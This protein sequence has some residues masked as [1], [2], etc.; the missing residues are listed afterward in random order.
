MERVM[1]ELAK[2][3]NFSIPDEG[4][5]QSPPLGGV[6]KR[7]FDI[8][9]A[10]CAIVVLS[11]LLVL[12]ALLVKL[13]DG[14]PIFYGHPRVGRGGRVFRCLKFRT[15]REDGDAV[16]AAYLRA[17]PDA[18][19]EWETTRKL[20]N[21]PR[22]TPVGVVLRKLSLDEL[23][24]IFNILAG[25]MSIVGPRP[26][27]KE[28]LEKYGSAAVFYLKSRPGLTGLWQVSG[29]NDVSYDARVDFD[30]R[31]VENWS[32]VQDIRIIVKT[33]PAVCLSRGS[34]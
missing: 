20:K 31:Y 21:D 29:R 22:V 9:G 17:N 3:T 34:Y 27:V 24:Q 1:R 23:P 33:V 16:L 11:P 10:L 28:E 15:M 19:M 32:L 8:F 25:E 2:S 14:G 13:S 7:G 12:I 6:I 18:R 26:V 5:D 30:R 4:I